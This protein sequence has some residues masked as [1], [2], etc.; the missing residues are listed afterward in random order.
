MSFLEFPKRLRSNNKKKIRP[1]IH[2]KR[3]KKK[4]GRARDDQGEEWREEKKN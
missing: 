2:E 1:T 3:K 4:I